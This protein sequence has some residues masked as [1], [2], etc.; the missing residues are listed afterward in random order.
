M[1]TS[2][3]K[4]GVLV[5][6]L[7][8]SQW[9]SRAQATLDLQTFFTQDIALTPDQVKTIRNGEPIAKELKARVPDE[10]FVFGA[11]RINADPESYVKFATDVDRLGKLPEYLAIGKFSDPPRLSDLK[12]FAF[13]SKDVAALK[14][15]KAGDCQIQLPAGH[16]EAAQKSINW[17]APD[18]ERQVN[19]LLQET[20]LKRLAEYQ[21]EGNLA[22]GEYNDARHPTVVSEHFKYM[23]SYARALPK[24][25]PEL[26]NYLLA[27]P[28]ARPANAVD[29]FQ[30]ANVN[31]GLKP[32][33]RI[34]H[35]VTMRGRTAEEP[36]W[37]IA[38]KQLYSS[39]YFETALDL[40]FCIQDREEGEPGFYLIRAMGSEQAGLTGFK[41]SIVR[42]VA[43]D[44]SVSSLE[45]SLAVIRKTLE[46][47]P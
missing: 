12:G 24:Y 25:L 15:C 13:D 30:W 29:T 37:V 19:A 26:N 46:Q 21:R 14:K 40:T 31:F 8:G 5:A 28:E 18:P 16:I 35:V 2:I 10:I 11:I 47:R 33:L 36:A 9:T 39:H 43:T 22:L 34:T 6:M 32:T 41:G 42:N 20:A 27:Y 7:V 45:K 17:S 38:E 4:I 44:R 3:A 23:L 1:R